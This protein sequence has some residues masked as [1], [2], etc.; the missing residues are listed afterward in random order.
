MEKILVYK[1][2]RKQQILAKQYDYWKSEGWYKEGD[3]PKVKK[4]KK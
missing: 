4:G 3:K 2:G 1:D